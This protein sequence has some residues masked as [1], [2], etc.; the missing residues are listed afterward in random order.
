MDA[1]LTPPERDKP[2]V[3][4]PKPGS[5]A[6][7]LVPL[8]ANER[9]P[10]PPAQGGAPSW[11]WTFVGVVMLLGV[12]GGVLAGF[13]GGMF[14]GRSDN[15]LYRLLGANLVSR[16]GGVY[17]ESF[18]A[19]GPVMTAGLLEGDRLEAIDGTTVRSVAQ[20]SRIITGHRTGDVVSLTIERNFRFAQYT[21]VLG[22]ITPTLPPVVT[23]L[24]P[25]PLPPQPPNGQQDEGRMGIRYSMIG[26]DDDFGVADGAVVERILT[27]GGP[28]DQAGVEVGDIIVSVNG[29]ALSQTYALLDAL[30]RFNEGDSITLRIV[31]NKTGE[32]LNLRV[33]L[34]G[35]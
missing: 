21:V 25:T 5:E 6:A 30:S 28:A 27:S 11:V 4:P 24:P 19:G 35:G 7:P 15:T 33:R 34:G 12:L 2:P 18:L 32:T 1:N 23:V 14:W 26:P 29:M 13:F 31:R 22:V 3:V 9:P 8:P 20:G 10:A 16:S 17:L